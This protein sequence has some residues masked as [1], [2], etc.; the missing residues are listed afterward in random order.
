MPLLSRLCR[1][2]L[3]RTGGGPAGGAVGGLTS[4][5]FT[6]EEKD[7]VPLDYAG[8]RILMYRGIRAHSVAK[9][10]HTVAWLEQNI[11]PADVF[12]D[13]GANVGAYA[14]VAG[15]LGGEGVRVYAFEPSVQNFPALLI[16]VS[17]N[18]L[19]N[20]VYPVNAA[21]AGTCRKDAF[22]YHSLA[23][24]AALHNLGRPRDYRGR[25]FAPAFSQTVITLTVDELV[26][27]YGFEPPTV[28]KI[29]VDGEE[30]EVIEGARRTLAA[31]PP[32]TIMVEALR[33]RYDGPATKRRVAD[34]LGEVG[35]ELCAEHVC[36]EDTC[37]LEFRPAP[38]GSGS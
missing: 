16:N 25:D 4:I 8:H 26:S 6:V 7:F 35:F 3:R 24:G 28:V 2:L 30:C 18:A 38:S 36:A 33:P 29:D 11:G 9:E 21:L 17:A 20:R 31:R 14:L 19:A 15:V 13:I 32:R 10:P 34:L 5:P 37:N 23:V 1:S 27:R 22:H 12:F